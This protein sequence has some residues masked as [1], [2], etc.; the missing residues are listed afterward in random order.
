[1][2]AEGE[3]HGE[4]TR[5][6]HWA[7]PLALTV[8]VFNERAG[9]G[10]VLG[11]TLIVVISGA[12]A[13]PRARLVFGGAATDRALDRLGGVNVDDLPEGVGSHS[14]HLPLSVA[15]SRTGALTA[16]GSESRVLTLAIP[17]SFFRAAHPRSR[18]PG[19][20]AVAAMVG[21]LCFLVSVG[22]CSVTFGHSV[23]GP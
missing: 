10:T 15:D 18:L 16:A 22:V 7:D 6:E 13:L 1:M 14:G 2:V 12:L 5:P 21:W 19:G 11:Q 9:C 20:V 23:Y 8:L 17:C 4:I 3:T